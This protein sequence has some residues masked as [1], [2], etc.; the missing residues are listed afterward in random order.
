MNRL[1]QFILKWQYRLMRRKDRAYKID[2]MSII[3]PAGHPLDWYQK[4]HPKYDQF[5]PVVAAELS[6]DAVVLDIGAN[7]GDSAI[8]FL[9]RGIETWCVEP[10]PEFLAYLRDN[11]QRN[12]LT[13]RAKI[14]ERIVTTH[15]DGAYLNIHDGTAALETD[16]TSNAMT[17]AISL[18]AILEQMDRIDL[19]KSDTD[20]WD[21]D[22][23]LSGLAQIRAKQPLIYFE[24]T[25]TKE[26]KEGYGQLYTSLKEIDYTHLIIFDNLGNV[27]QSM[28]DWTAL[29]QINLEILKG[30]KSGL[31]Y[32]DVL[33][34]TDAHV[35][36]MKKV[37]GKY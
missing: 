35:D 25:V 26:N 4:L 22:V 19:I 24:N 21:Y 7:I 11:L 36:F 31:P 1:S 34:G 37:I 32:T 14:I 2:G 33:V 9:K 3:L 29:D 13:D 10:A 6:K 17:N 15:L 30:H 20:G 18:D 23:L 5:L 28:T 8:P 16:S 27:M 12:N